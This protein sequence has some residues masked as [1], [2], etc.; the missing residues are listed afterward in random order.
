MATITAIKGSNTDLEYYQNSELPLVVAVTDSDGNP[1]DLSGKA[2][3]LHIK[4]YKSDTA[5]LA[6][7]TVGSGIAIGGASNNELTFSG[8][9]DLESGVV[10]YDC[11]NTDDNDP[12]MYGQFIVY[13]NVYR[14]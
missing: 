10:Y 4:Y 12:I 14:T 6:A 5:T 8:Q 1:V 2:I 9:Y 11:I 7:L 3:V 13:G